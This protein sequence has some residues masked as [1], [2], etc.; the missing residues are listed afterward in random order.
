MQLAIPPSVRALPMTEFVQRAWTLVGR[1][2]AKQRLLE[3]IYR[4]AQSSVGLPIA[5]DSEAVAMFRLV[6]QE[7]LTLCQLRDQIEERANGYLQNNPDYRRLRQIPGIGPIGTLTILAEAG[8]LR[9][10]QLTTASS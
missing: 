6:L 8:D 4:T 3:G 1:K 5:A 9:R 2:V 7:M 10:L